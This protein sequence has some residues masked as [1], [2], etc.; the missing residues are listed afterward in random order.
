MCSYSEPSGKS[1]PDHIVVPFAMRDAGSNPT[2][3]HI[4]L[5]KFF[6]YARPYKYFLS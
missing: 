5:I 1:T 4:L 2:G 3:G 6:E